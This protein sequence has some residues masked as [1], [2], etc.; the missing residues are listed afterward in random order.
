MRKTYGQSLILALMG[1]YLTGR[2]WEKLEMVFYHEIQHRAVD[3]I[4]LGWIILLLFLLSESAARN[5]VLERKQKE[6][7]QEPIE[8]ED[9]DNDYNNG[10]EGNRK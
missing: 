3:N 7:Q 2:I 9:V 10:Y 1:G 5:F 4:V 6:L 8:R